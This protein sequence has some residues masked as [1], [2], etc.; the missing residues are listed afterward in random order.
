MQIN[1]NWLR[2]NGRRLLLIVAMI[3][4][5]LAVQIAAYWLRFDAEFD[6]AEW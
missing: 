5:F 3:P 4:V 6:A 1:W 2:T